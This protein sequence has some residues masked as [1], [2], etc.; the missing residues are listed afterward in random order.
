MKKKLFILA[1]MPLIYC[2]VNAQDSNP[3][4]YYWYKNTQIP[5]EKGNQK[6]IIY[7]DALLLESDKEK[8][9]ESGD[10]S[11]P[12]RIN[13]K[14]GTTK[15]DAVIE[16]L[17]H[18]LYCMPSYTIGDGSNIFVTHRFYVKLWQ[19][20]DLSVLQD[21]ATQY[22]AEIEKDSDLPLWY[23]LRSDLLSS[24][25]ALELANIFYESGLFS[26]AEPEFMGGIIFDDVE[27]T[28]ATVSLPKNSATREIRN[29]HLYIHHSEKTYDTLG[30][31][32]K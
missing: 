31:E 6:Y 14:W 3:P 12:G 5:L 24:F 30:A 13:L 23:I 32:V 7:D 10:V 2:I 19:S 15:P 11:Y 8:L 17:E 27:N 25:N 9:L 20:D 4:A 16:D 18:V 22:N 28:A 26:A 21:M 1:L 29:G